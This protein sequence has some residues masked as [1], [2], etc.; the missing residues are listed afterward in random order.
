MLIPSGNNV[1]RFNPYEYQ[2]KTVAAIEEQK[3]SQIVKGRQLGISQIITTWML[4]R[5]VTEPAFTGVVLSKTQQD[6]SQLAGRMR[7]MAAQL[8]DYF[9]LAN[10][11][12]LQLKVVGGGQIFFR[13]STIDACRGIPSVSVLFFDEAAFV[14]NI[15]L[16]YSAATPALAMCGDD[17]RIIMASTPNG[18]TGNY[19]GETLVSNCENDPIETMDRIRAGELEPYHDLV[20]KAGWRKIFIHWKA[21]P[22]Y[23]KN[24]NYIE[25]TASALNEDISNVR[26]EYDLSFHDVQEV[27]FDSSLVKGCRY[28]EDFDKEIDPE[29]LHFVGVDCAFGGEDY[30]V[31]LVGKETFNEQD[32]PCLELVDMYRKNKGSTDSH[33][34]AVSDQIER[35][36]AFGIVIED[37]GGGVVVQERLSTDYSDRVVKGHTTTN[38]SKTRLIEQLKFVMQRGWL[39]YQ[40]RKFKNLTTE[41]L[42]FRKKGEKMEAAH[43]FHDD[44]VM[45]L[46]LLVESW[47]GT[48]VG[49]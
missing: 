46:A 48:K 35:Y 31:S 44:T 25:D 37:N 15:K 39:R 16:I 20:D 33:I 27:I 47:Y 24:P 49:S 14:D 22:I 36:D 26:R 3:C 8:S 21:H 18:I 12:L 13:N 38:K 2:L 40:E 9:T 4:Y 5:A 17:A 28:S 29:K 10:E 30:F 19:F 45:A 6:T 32:E 41:L 11:S 23:G 7:E 1:V 42:N 43:G 34:V